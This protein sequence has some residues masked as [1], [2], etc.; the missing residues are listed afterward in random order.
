MFGNFAIIEI[1]T[2]ETPLLTKQAY[3]PPSLYGPSVELAGGVS[4]LLDQRLKLIKSIAQ[5]KEEEG[6]YHVQAWS[7]PCILVIGTNPQRRS[8]DKRNRQSIETFSGRPRRL[9]RQE[10]AVGNSEEIPERGDPLGQECPWP[11]PIRSGPRSSGYG[12]QADRHGMN[13]TI[14]QKIKDHTQ[15]SNAPSCFRCIR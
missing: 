10:R 1:K 9:H 14:R 4:Q 11:P 5:K 12:R 15:F 6:N 13:F 3:R 8:A 7:T 2:T